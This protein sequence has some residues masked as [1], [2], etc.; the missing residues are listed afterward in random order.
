MSKNEFSKMKFLLESD[1]SEDG[2]TGNDLKCHFEGSIMGV[3]GML[4]QVSTSEHSPH[5]AKVVLMVAAALAKHKG[6]DE[7]ASE[8]LMFSETDFNVSSVV[9]ENKVDDETEEGNDFN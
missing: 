9:K 7:L 4:F 2:G 3:G 6:K 1:T 8:I 5:V